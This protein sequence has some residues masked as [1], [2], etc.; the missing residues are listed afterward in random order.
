VHCAITLTPTT[1]AQLARD[2]AAAVRT[3]AF[4][5]ERRQRMGQAS[6]AR[7]EEVGLWTSKTRRMSELY[8]SIFLSAVR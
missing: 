3:L 8:S 7:V 6:R 5:V 4:D 2:V 1:P